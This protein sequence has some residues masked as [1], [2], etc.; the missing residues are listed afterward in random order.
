M[1]HSDASSDESVDESKIPAWARKENLSKSMGK[2][3]SLDPDSV[4]PDP[5]ADC[6]LFEIFSGFRPKKRYRDRT[7]TGNWSHDNAQQW[8]D[9]MQY[10]N[11]IQGFKKKPKTE[12]ENPT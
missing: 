12:S 2:Q 8:D 4:F 10:K 11:L 5:V 1:N 6:N 7:S 3:R 9:T